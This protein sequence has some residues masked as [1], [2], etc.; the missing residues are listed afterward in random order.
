MKLSFRLGTPR[1]TSPEEFKRLLEFLQ[2][3]KECVDE[4]SLF[5][6]YWHHGYYPLQEFK[7]LCEILRD[8]IIIL[9]SREFKSVGI[10]MLDTIGHVNEAWDILPKLPFQPIVGHDGAISKCAMCPNSEGFKNYISEKYRLVALADPDFIWVD[11]DIRM[12]GHSVAFGCFCEKCISIFNK[13]NGTN[14]SR[15]ELVNL[16][17]TKEGAKLREKWVEQNIETIESLLALIEKTIHGVNENIEIGLMSPIN[18]WTTYSGCDYERWLKALK[19]KK[20]RP[21]GGF[22][23]DNEPLVLLSKVLECSR[24]RSELP[25]EV[26]DF[27]YELENFPY[28]RLMKS[29]QITIVECTAAIASG[30]NGIAFNALKQEK[31]SLDDYHDL[32]KSISEIKPAWKIMDKIAR[33]FRNAGLYSTLSSHHDARR[34]VENGNWFEFSTGD[35]DINRIYSLCEIGIP[36]TTIK[37]GACGTVL[38]GN[39]AEGFTMDELKEMLC[40][41]IIM[42]AAALEDL[43]DM[44]L[45][46][47]CGVSIKAKYD[48]GVLEQI[49]G[50]EVNGVHAGEQRDARISFYA[51]K[52]CVLEPMDD[53]VR[54]AAELVDYAGNILGPTFTL[55]ENELG[56]RIAVSGYTA[57]KQIHNSAKRDQIMNVCDWICKG[58]L[59][60][61]IEKCVKVTPFIRVS[62]DET[63][64]ILMLLNTSFDE[65]GGFDVEIKVNSECLYEIQKDGS[66]L[67]R[68][69]INNNR[70]NG[71]MI[72]RVGNI[73]PWD[74]ILIYAGRKSLYS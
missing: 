1:Y 72:Y 16:L 24:L 18:N 62:Q 44:G 26:T 2:Q 42:D 68:M 39:M 32:M 14:F 31:G 36:I 5:T 52:G 29:R 47:Y 48:N 50:D 3:H 54:V 73:K 46:R 66:L 61:R 74:F 21:G 22:Y 33:N 65:T 15:K 41:G 40:G 51:D 4:I 67:H 9:K 13:A 28:H 56:G 57:W 49:T 53:S 20:M 34:S 71:K 30:L 11:D 6:E 17:N 37:D 59:P 10:N 70:T 12:H 69:E 55:Y 43:C 19:A 38:S 8:R 23:S 64:C 45:G 60:V 7:E 27:Q 25:P 58:R 63:Q 35:N